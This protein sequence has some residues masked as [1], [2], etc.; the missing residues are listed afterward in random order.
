MRR[1]SRNPHDAVRARSD[2]KIVQRFA[3]VRKNERPMIQKSAQKNLQA[4]ITTNIV[5][6][7]PY[8]RNSWRLASLDRIRQTRQRMANQFGKAARAG[9]KEYPLGFPAFA[10]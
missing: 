2:Q 1:R 9:R 6:R 8:D 5:E 4:A 10:S 3:G 7:T